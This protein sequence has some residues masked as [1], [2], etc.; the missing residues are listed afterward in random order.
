MLSIDVSRQL[1]SEIARRELY[2]FRAT[3]IP[4]IFRLLPRKPA[5]VTAI[6]PCLATPLRRYFA[7]YSSAKRRAYSYIRFRSIYS[8]RFLMMRDR[9]RRR[10]EETMRI[11]R[12]AI[13]YWWR[14]ILQHLKY[15]PA[16]TRRGDIDKSF[17]MLDV[18]A[19]WYRELLYGT[20][21][22]YSLQ[23]TIRGH[24]LY[25]ATLFAQACRY[26]SFTY[27]NKY[28]AYHFV[29]H[30]AMFH[31]IYFAIIYLIFRTL[32]L[33]QLYSCQNNKLYY[34]FICYYF[35]PH[36]AKMGRGEISLLHYEIYY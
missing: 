27:K 35:A 19:Y 33:L 24:W 20:L 23:F 9:M 17:D 32:M 5:I 13:I 34:Q 16:R 30:D 1:C 29:P 21:W 11:R 8:T 36:T 12:L 31:H 14:L 26:C 4:P 6:P 18:G 10:D 2:D 3:R 25:F 7:Y 15:Q 22:D 28:F